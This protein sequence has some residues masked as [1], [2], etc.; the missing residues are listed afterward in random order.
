MRAAHNF[1]P[2]ALPPTQPDDARLHRH[3]DGSVDY[4][5]ALAVSRQLGQT[6]AAQND[7]EQLARLLSHYR[8]AYGENPVGVDISGKSP[9]LL[10]ANPKRIRFIEHPTAPP[11]GATS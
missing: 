8:F 9:S 11:C 2:R 4:L 1:P 5:P 7:L 10:G 3:A 6:T